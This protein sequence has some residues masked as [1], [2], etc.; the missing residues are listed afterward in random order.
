[1]TGLWM[2]AVLALSSVQ[3]G[4]HVPEAGPPPS[5]EAVLAIPQE[6]RS[7]FHEQVLEPAASPE[8]RMER[9]V[10]FVFDRQGLGIS[11][12]PNATRTIAETFR[13]RTV[14][15]LSSTLLVVA[16]ARE[17]GFKAQGQ[18][19]DRVLAWGAKG[20]LAIQSQH[21]NAIIEAPGGRRFVVDVDST[22]VWTEDA[23]NPVDD[24]QLF[25]Y[26]YGNRAMELLMEGRDS[27]AREWMQEALRHWPEDASLLNNAGVMALRTGDA[28]SAE[29]L[30][31]RAVAADR[32]QVSVLSNL[33]A[34]YRRQGD[35]TREAQW[36]ARSESVLRKAPYYQYQIGAQREEAGDMQLAIRHYRRAA[37]LNRSEHRF[38]FALARAYF[39]VGDLRRAERELTIAE[40][41][42]D[43]AL[44]ARYQEKLVAL[45]QMRH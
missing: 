12:Q 32:R 22:G 44:R 9:L 39:T 14:N 25:A 45:R 42:S 16:L 37:S 30:F 4:G 26:F 34:L 21:A 23:L 17:A 18:R 6:L 33:I 28:R 24:A 1:M 5:P 36:K 7:A 27:E 10:K 3:Q 40:G 2:V 19:V 35:L 20:E 41:L 15:C 29:A 11:Y 38:R 8:A 13:A 31:L 43:G